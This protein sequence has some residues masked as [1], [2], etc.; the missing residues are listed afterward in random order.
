MAA[1]R[2]SV[3]VADDV[4]DVKRSIELAGLKPGET[5]HVRSET[6]RADGSIWQAEAAFI[7]RPDGK[8]RLT[9]DAPVSGSYSGVSSMGLVWSQSETKTPDATRKPDLQESIR[10]LTIALEVRTGDGSVAS[11]S[12]VQRYAG[13]GVVRR[14][15]REDGLVGT[16]FLPASEGPHPAVMIMNGSGGGINEQRA[17]LYASRGYAALALGYFAAPG[18]S[19]YISNTN[20][21][22]FQK[23]LRWIRRELRPARNFVAIT[24]QSRGGEL[25]LLLGSLFPEEVSAVMAYVPAAYIH[26]GQSAADPELGR[27]SATWLF[28]G[29][30]L[31]HL[32]ENNRTGTYEP[33][34]SGPV[35]RRLEHTIKTAL[36]DRKAAERARIPVEKIRAPVLLVQGTDDGWWPTDYYCDVVEETLKDAK[37]AYPVKRLRY[38]DAGHSILFPYVPTT[39]IVHPHAVSGILSTSGGTPEANAVANEQSWAGVH[40]FLREAFDAH[41]EK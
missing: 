38:V 17:A 37:H 25:V 41:R 39:L 10:P 12:F 9:E 40:D 8:V 18:L 14:E 3:D 28:Q 35:P 7:A 32:W 13:P 27:K 4:I 34:D 19:P 11:D 24:G 6:R 5:V 33:Y 31:P 36:A 30:P 29:K 23:G 16:L 15:I 21:E 22:Y 26:S 1:P 20:L 2:F